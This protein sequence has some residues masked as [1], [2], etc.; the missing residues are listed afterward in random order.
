[1]GLFSP[2]RT[3]SSTKRMIRNR[4]FVRDYKQNKK[5]EICGY[6]KYP[7]L[8]IFHH[9]NKEEK[10]K[11]VNILMKTLKNLEIIKIEIDKCLLLCSNCHREL[12]LNER[13]NKENEKE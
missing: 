12:H 7:E 8:L 1:M 10:N 3:N 5:C 4:K 6:N 13:R 2:S 9:K 11:G